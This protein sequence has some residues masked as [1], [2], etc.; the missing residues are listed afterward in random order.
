VRRRRE[1]GRVEN[2]PAKGRGNKQGAADTAS[3]RRAQLHETAGPGRE[4]C[5]LFRFFLSLSVSFEKL[6]SGPLLRMLSL[7]CNP[8][9]I[10]C[11]RHP[12][13]YA[14]P[15][16]PSR[17]RAGAYETTSDLSLSFTPIVNCGHATTLTD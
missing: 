9:P 16:A 1:V 12:F 8:K 4:V 14:S 11:I 10:V 7:S 2:C 15:P 3:Q 13:L 17:Y 5:E 6:R